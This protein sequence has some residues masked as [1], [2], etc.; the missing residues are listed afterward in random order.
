MPSTLTFHADA[1]LRV[2][3]LRQLG[4]AQTSVEM[5]YFYWRTEYATF[6]APNEVVR[7][8]GDLVRKGVSVRVVL[9]FGMTDAA[10]RY[11][12]YQTGLAL[13]AQGVQVRYAPMNR[14]MH[15]KITVIDNAFVF[16]GSHNLTRGAL[17][18]NY[19]T[20][21]STRDTILASRIV[22]YFNALWSA[23]MPHEQTTAPPPLGGGEGGEVF[24][25]PLAAPPL[26][27]TVHPQ[28]GAV[29]LAWT[30]VAAENFATYELRRATAAGVTE[31]SSLLVTLDTANVASIVDTERNPALPAHYRLWVFNRA[32]QGD[33]SPEV[34]VAALYIPQITVTNTRMEADTIVLD[35]A[36]NRTDGLGGF[37]G[38]AALTQDLADAEQGPLFAETERSVWVRP[39]AEPGSTVWV[40]VAALAEGVEVARSAAVSV[41][42]VL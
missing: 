16:L 40:A 28:T 14:T 31:D 38:L 18:A 35:F 29:T 39:T 42:Y 26:T 41:V 15:S 11:Q 36:V 2:P 24:V 17:T 27:A 13:H 19:E 21:L 34:G 1:D 30:P 25:P 9:G 4:R 5:A 23:S 12:N 20:T 8:C 32:A 33:A 7:V 3:L 37:T 22:G 10:I 6:A